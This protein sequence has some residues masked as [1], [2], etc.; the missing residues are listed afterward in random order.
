MKDSNP[1]CKLCEI[2]NGR[3]RF[4]MGGLLKKRRVSAVALQDEVRACCLFI[5]YFSFFGFGGGGGGAGKECP[6]ARS[7]AATSEPGEWRDNRVKTWRLDTFFGSPVH[8]HAY[9]LCFASELS[10]SALKAAFMRLT[11]A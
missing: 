2:S 6:G 8:M 3:E 5:F 1:D 9:V 10:G 4:N 11:R 7:N